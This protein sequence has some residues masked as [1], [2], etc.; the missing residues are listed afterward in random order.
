MTDA[1]DNAT[2]APAAVEHEPEPEQDRV[3][4]VGFMTTM[5]GAWMGLCSCWRMVTL[6]TSI[7]T[8]PHPQYRLHLFLLALGSLVVIYWGRCWSESRDKRQGWRGLRTILGMPIAL[9][10]LWYAASWPAVLTGV[11]IMVAVPV[12]FWLH[13][14]A[15]TPTAP[16]AVPTA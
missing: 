14:R 9:A 10:A 1:P 5:T 15:H 16:A 7:E 4:V 8:W 11:I 13:R 3:A 2:P 12:A 6:E